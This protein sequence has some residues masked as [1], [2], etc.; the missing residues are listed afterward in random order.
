[1][2]ATAVPIRLEGACDF[3]SCSEFSFPL[4][5]QLASGAY[6]RCSTLAI[7]ETIDEWRDEHRTA[8]KRANRAARLGYTAGPILRHQHTD[9]IYRIN[10]S[11]P[12]RQGRRMTDGY[13]Q[14]PA[15]TVDVWPCSRHGVHPYGVLAPTGELVAYLWMYRAGDLALVSQILGHADYLAANVMYL[16]FEHALAGETQVPGTVVYNRHD[17]G[18]NGLRFFKER[19]GFEEADVE[20]LL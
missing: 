1:M 8:R 16:L 5:R 3:P 18:T 13:W 7:P 19:L 11:T 6:N 10:T 2:I 9:A 12:E 17:S 20:W 4:Y 14:R 15:E